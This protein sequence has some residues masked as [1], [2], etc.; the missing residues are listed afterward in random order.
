MDEGGQPVC[1][2]LIG[3]NSDVLGIVPELD[4]INLSVVT[5]H[6]ERLGATPHPPDEFYS[7][8]LRDSSRVLLTA[9]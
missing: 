5:T 1:N 6:Q 7:H 2:H 9:L 3:K 4:N 8:D